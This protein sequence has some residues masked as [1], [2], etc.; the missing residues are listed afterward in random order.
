MSKNH[1]LVTGPPGVG[2]T[3]LIKKVADKL[4]N[5]RTIQGFYTAEVRDEKGI[6]SGFDVISITDET[7]RKAL[8]RSNVPPAVKGP[9]VSKYTVMV[10]DFESVAMESLKNVSPKSILI[11]DEIGKVVQHTIEILVVYEIIH[12]IMTK[13]RLFILALKKQI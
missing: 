6:R 5:K 9:K 10:Q 7:V 3:T 1:I 2:K 8:A 11:I 4:R 13:V 12:H